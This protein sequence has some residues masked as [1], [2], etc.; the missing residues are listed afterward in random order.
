VKDAS[1]GGKAR[2][3]LQASDGVKSAPCLATGTLATLITNQ[4]V[5]QHSVVKIIEY[6]VNFVQDRK[7]LILLQG[8]PVQHPGYALGSPVQLDVATGAGG[9]VRPQRPPAPRSRRV[10]LDTRPPLP[11]PHPLLIPT[12]LSLRS[13]LHTTTAT[14][15][16]ARAAGPGSLWRGV[17]RARERLWRRRVFV[18]V[19]RG[20]RQDARGLR[21][22]RRWR[23]RWRWRLLRRRRRR[24]GPAGHADR[25]AEPVQ[26]PLDDQ[27]ARDEQVRCA[28]VEQRQVERQH[29]QGRAA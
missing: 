2:F 7:I 25:G 21:R 11:A 20:R 17:R 26:Q 22:G 15:F 8:E 18:L 24:R 1:A 23:R 28:H 13:H 9:E 10:P 4:S 3:R 5:K 16:P 14:T 12:P 29:V 27:G 19:V 6:Q